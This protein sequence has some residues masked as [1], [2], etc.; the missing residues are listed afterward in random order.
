MLSVGDRG[1]A[2]AAGPGCL[3]CT[4]RC[5]SLRNIVCRR[6]SV[7]DELASDILSASAAA[8]ASSSNADEGDHAEQHIYCQQLDVEQLAALLFE[9]GAA[10]DVK[11]RNR[12]LLYTISKEL[13]KAPGR[14]KKRAAAA[15]NGDSSDQHQQ[16]KQKKQKVRHLTLQQ[17]NDNGQVD[18]QQEQHLQQA[19]LDTSA[20]GKRTKKHKH[21]PAAHVQ[22]FLQQHA[23]V[24]GVTPSGSQTQA[25]A[26]QR[27]RQVEVLTD[28]TSPAAAADVT[29]QAATDSA[30]KSSKKR[31]KSAT[32]AAP[33]GQTEA[34]PA[35]TADYPDGSRRGVV[36][37]LQKNVYFAHGAPVPPEAVRTP[38]P[39]KPKGS[40]LKASSQTVPVRKL[41]SRLDAV[42]GA[43]ERRH[44][45]V[46]P[47]SVPRVKAAAFF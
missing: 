3:N 45:P 17:Q 47:N 28:G 35:A 8:G 6:E 43:Q 23:D 41:S 46:T 25:I 12:Q 19:V 21:P 37:N 42:A 7:F 26:Q 9:R 33:S 24:S 4:D 39:A 30:A 10:D 14:H 38:P 18:M 11:A 1:L 29:P 5:C 20:P 44:K 13:E 15:A 27:Q 40:A 32:A 34:K 31:R 36:I 2:S 16:A 22:G